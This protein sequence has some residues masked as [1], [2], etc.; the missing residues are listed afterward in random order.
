MPKIA[1]DALLLSFVA[2]FLTLAA[3]FLNFED[4]ST[5]RMIAVMAGA[6]RRRIK[7]TMTGTSSFDTPVLSM[8]GSVSSKFGD[9]AAD[10]SDCERNNKPHIA[11]S[12][13][14]LEQES[15]CM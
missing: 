15:N 11:M 1:T 3:A 7:S 9:R 10:T 14:A 2:F 5:V 4:A 13:A 8:E 12:I 6:A